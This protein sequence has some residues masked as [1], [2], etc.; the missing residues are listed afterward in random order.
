[1]RKLLLFVILLFISLMVLE[2]SDTFGLFET[3]NVITVDNNIAKWQINV[4][5][6]SI[7]DSV[8]FVV[9]NYNISSDANVKE[10]RIAPGVSAYF[11]IDIN[12][13]DT[14]VS[15][16]YDIN[17]DLSG[18][19][20][21]KIKIVNV[22]E[23]NSNPLIVNDDTYVGIIP[24]SDSSIHHI[25]VYIDWENSDDNNEVDSL[26]GT[27]GEKN[28]EIVANIKFSQYLGEEITNT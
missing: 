5:N 28:V 6:S 23:L 25:R 21:E 17:F 12:P 3:N 19:E 14:S 20:N 18:L 13:N 22:E 9:N 24:I 11:D 2:I 15:I 8:H 27:Y 4:N 16:R 7:N 26:F 10:G 1:M